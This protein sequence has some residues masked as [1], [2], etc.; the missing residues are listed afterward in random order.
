MSTLISKLADLVNHDNIKWNWKK[1]FNIKV[2]GEEKRI[3][4]RST[5]K[6]SNFYL[7][8]L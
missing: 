2:E 4:K 6:N 8:N 3:T 7:E 1:S 5:A